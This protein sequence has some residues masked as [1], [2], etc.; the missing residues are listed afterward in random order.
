MKTSSDPRHLH[1]RHLVQELFTQIFDPKQLPEDIKD[2]VEHLEALDA[3]I[4]AAAPEWPLDKINR[5]DLAI[6]RLAT[7]ELLISGKEPVKVVIDEAVELAK[8]F[9]AE[10]SPAFINGALGAVVKSKNLSTE[11]PDEPVTPATE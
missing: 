10:G 11:D 3:D 8:E 5:V 6:L 4:A 1:R 7:Y 2:I 9:G